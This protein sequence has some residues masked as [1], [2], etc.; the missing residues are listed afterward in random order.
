[1]P[2][3]R[4]HGIEVEPPAKNDKTRTW[5]IRAVP[6]RPPQQPD[7]KPQQSQEK[8]E[9]LGGLG[10]LGCSFPYPTGDGTDSQPVTVGKQQ[11]EQPATAF[12]GREANGLGSGGSLG[13]GSGNGQ[14]S[15]EQ[16][17]LTIPKF[18]RRP[19]VAADDADDPRHLTISAKSDLRAIYDEL[20]LRDESPSN[21]NG[22]R[23]DR[24]HELGNSLSGYG[25]E[26]PR[27]QSKR[28]GWPYTPSSLRC[29]R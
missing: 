29:S 18:L 27:P 26:P 12:S 2:F 6:D 9:G 28:G 17:D 22:G 20:R 4:E 14:Q 23:R 5:H 3:L 10:G 16:P 21:S 8:S 11:P 24:H 7:D 15:P 19:P 13:D 1:M 25:F